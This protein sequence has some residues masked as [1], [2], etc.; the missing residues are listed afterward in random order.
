MQIFL[1]AFA[2][3]QWFGWD[4]QFFSWWFG[5]GQPGN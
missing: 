3:V 4:L 1:L 5:G 2:V